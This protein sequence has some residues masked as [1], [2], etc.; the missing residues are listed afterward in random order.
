MTDFYP[1]THSLESI[2]MV[3]KK[4]WQNLGKLTDHTVRFLKNL[5]QRMQNNQNVALAVL[6]SA[7]SVFFLFTYSF[8]NWLD[9]RCEHAGHPS[10]LND[11]EKMMKH[12]ILNLIAGSSVLTFN[13]F[14]SKVTKYPLTNV[15]LTLITTALIAAHILLNLISAKNEV[16]TECQ[17]IVSDKEKQPQENLTNDEQDSGK[18]KVEEGKDKLEETSSE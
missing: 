15:S 1:V 12:L 2:H 3:F 6:S 14:L 8:T 17:A 11:D 18:S 4:E 5:P 9:R 16:I 7:N 13:V 10:D